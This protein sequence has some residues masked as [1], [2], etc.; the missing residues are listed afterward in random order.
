MTTND[1]LNIM[2]IITFIYLLSSV[3]YFNYRL[4]KIEKKIKNDKQ[5]RN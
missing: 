3:I 4:E 5:F 2:Y 1:Y